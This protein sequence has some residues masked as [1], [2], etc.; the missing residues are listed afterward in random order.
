MKS[1]ET[2]LTEIP[3]MADEAW[4]TKG[5]K[6]VSSDG[7]RGRSV[8]GSRC[9]ADLD[10]ML[11][12]SG[13]NDYDGLGVLAGWVRMI[14]EE[15]DELRLDDLQD[16][17]RGRERRQHLLPD[18]LLPDA[19]GEALHDVQVDVR[20]EE[21]GPDLLESLVDVELRQVT[22]TPEPLHHALQTVGQ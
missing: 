2:M 3:D 8:P 22:L 21:P 13:G 1:I 20:L 4:W 17:L 18:G 6:V 7:H 5:T 19:L 11:A 16:L 15:R 9:L 12:L 10:R 14:A